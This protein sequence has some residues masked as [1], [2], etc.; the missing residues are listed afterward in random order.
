MMFNHRRQSQ[1]R[2]LRE[3]VLAL[4]PGTLYMS[5]YSAKQFGEN[6]KIAV[7]EGFPNIT[8]END[9]YFAE[10]VEI[11]LENVT[12]LIIYRWNRRYPAD[13]R[14]AFDLSALGF[15]KVSAEDFIGNSHPT[16][17]EEIYKKAR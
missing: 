15:A 8:G 9:Y 4:V 14:F 7:C 2:L 13:K 12:K 11:S 16:I 3:R 5:A 17:T 10:D 1:D 6:E